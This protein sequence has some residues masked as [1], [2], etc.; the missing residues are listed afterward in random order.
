MGD[1]VDY[2]DLSKIPKRGSVV[3]ENKAYKNLL[4]A[5]LPKSFV[6]RNHGHLISLVRGRFGI[7]DV[8]GITFF[9]LKV[10]ALE[11]IRRF[12]KSRCPCIWRGLQALQILCYP[13]FKWIQ[14]WEPFKN[15]VDSMQVLS[16]P[17]LALSIATLFSDLSKCSDGKSDCSTDSQDAVAYSELSPLQVDLNTGKC[18]TDPKILESEKWL[19]LLIQELENQ[20][21]SLPERINDDE[22]SRFYAA[23][24]NDFSCFL[25]SIKKTIRWRETYR[26]LSE[27]ELKMWSKMVFWH[28]SDVGHRP[29][30]IVRLGLACS[31]L[32][33]E[34]RP[35]FAQAVISQVEYGVLHL[36]DAG[37]P[38][39]TVL[40]DCE[41]LPPVRIP[42]QIIRS[43]SSLLQ[44]HFPNCLGCMFVIRL[45]ANVLVISQTFIQTL[46]PATR[47]KLKIEG[48]M[49][50]KVLSDYL[51]KL[52][53]YLGGCC[54]CMK[55]SNIDHGNMLQTYATG[56]SRRD[57][58]EDTTD[59]DNDNE[60]SPTLHPSNELEGNLYANYDQLLRT[61]IV[62]ILMFWVFIALGALVFDPSN[63]H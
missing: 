35:R 41:G 61:A 12:S 52:P 43:C 13:P 50:Q 4:I 59:R 46:E 16:R 30:L 9:L 47:N 15:L 62:G 42:M 28:G 22:L 56:T 26:I 44:D 32:T 34:D 23:S 60:D 57:G 58:L 7:R 37:N 6:Q 25:T 19:T 21:L 29:C 27:E 54:T 48:E 3:T 11:I 31:T 33:S 63:L 24:N 55:C 10:A 20:G 5:S 40:V 36:V 49:Y 14:R 51:P 8:G 2:S 53:S 45:P 39:I 17:L 18:L 38:Q 1:M